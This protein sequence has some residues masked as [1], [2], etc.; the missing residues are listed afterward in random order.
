MILGSYRNM[1]SLISNRMTV[2]EYGLLPIQKERDVTIPIQSRSFFLPLKMLRD[3]REAHSELLNS[4]WMARS[5][6]LHMVV[7]LL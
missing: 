2:E 1:K 7:E 6:L 3:W 5:I 4:A